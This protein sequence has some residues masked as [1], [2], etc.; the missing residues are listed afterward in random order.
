MLS[1]ILDRIQIKLFIPVKYWES[2]KLQKVYWIL[3]R[4]IQNR[5]IC[6]R[7]TQI[8]CQICLMSFYIFQKRM[9]LMFYFYFLF[10]KKEHNHWQFLTVKCNFERRN[11]EI[12]WKV[13]NWDLCSDPCSVW[14]TG[15]IN[16]FAL[17]PYI[18]FHLKE[19]WA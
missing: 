12:H 8:T 19:E 3:R 10:L 16:V 2:N 9:L 18:L 15:P 11:S 4:W 5:P 14:S 6:S 7:L 13:I 1:V 17:L